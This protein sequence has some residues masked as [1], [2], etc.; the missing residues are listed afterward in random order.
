M[1][2]S[3]VGSRFN[4]ARRARTSILKSGFLKLGIF[5]P[6]NLVNG[7]HKSL[8]VRALRE[9]HF[10]ARSGDAEIA[11]AA[12]AGLVHPPSLEPAAFLQA[13]KHGVE[14][15]HVKTQ[16]SGR[17]GLDQLADLISM[18]LAILHQGKNQEFSAAF[19]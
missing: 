3:L 8:P 10:L 7:G 16:R 11:A 2:A 13:V 19:F 12:L 4:R 14:R 1:A 6:R 5:N 17:A 9:Q 15:G 18:A